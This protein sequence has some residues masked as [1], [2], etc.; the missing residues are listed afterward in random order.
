MKLQNM[1]LLKDKLAPLEASPTSYKGE[2]EDGNEQG[3]DDKAFKTPTKCHTQDEEVSDESS[4][5]DDELS[6]IEDDGSIEAIMGVAKDDDGNCILYPKEKTMTLRV[7]FS[8]G[9]TQ[10]GD[11]WSIHLDA[12]ELLRDYLVNNQ[13]ELDMAKKICGYKLPKKY[14]R[15]KTQQEKLQSVITLNKP[16]VCSKEHKSM[17][18]YSPIDDPAYFREGA[19]FHFDSCDMCRDALATKMNSNNPAYLCSNQTRGCDAR[20]C[21]T[22]YIKLE[23]GCNVRRRRNKN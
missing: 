2:T 15:K 5:Q 8:T 18:S 21:S 13:E 6:D 17:A 9:E 23:D 1:G 10:D 4:T 16:Y 19:R 12:E 11:F 22:C 14:Q 7:H 3:T 20:L